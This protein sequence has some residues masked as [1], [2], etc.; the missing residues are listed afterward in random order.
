M[1]ALQQQNTFFAAATLDPASASLFAAGGGSCTMMEAAQTCR[2]TAMS[3][4]SS[5][6][7]MVLPR[8]A[9][10]SHP[11][12]GTSGTA[13]TPCPNGVET[14]VTSSG[15]LRASA[16]RL[17]PRLHRH[18]DESVGLTVLHFCTTAGGGASAA[19][20]RDGKVSPS[21]LALQILEHGEP[22][23]AVT[24]SELLAAPGKRC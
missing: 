4:A 9:R 11:C 22:A 6:T 12:A 3:V 24:K 13:G 1:G 15:M 19:C 17:L 8:R 14:Q 7:G 10:V 5:T 2:A 23:P 16:G 21:C 20:P 18:H